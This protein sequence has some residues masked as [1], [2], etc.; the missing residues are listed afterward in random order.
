MKKNAATGP[1]QGEPSRSKTHLTVR[2]HPD[3]IAALDAA[4]RITGQPVADLLREAILEWLKRNPADVLMRRRA[5]QVQE[6]ADL[7]KSL[8]LN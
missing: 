3:L 8:S 2:A 4:A 5:E 6:D 1:T 7:L